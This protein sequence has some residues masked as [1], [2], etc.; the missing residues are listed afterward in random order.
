MYKDYFNSLLYLVYY[1]ESSFP[2]YPAK[3]P[4]LSSRDDTSVASDRSFTMPSPLG[5]YEDNTQQTERYTNYEELRRRNRNQWM[6]AGQRQPATGQRE[7][8][9]QIFIIILLFIRYF[10]QQI[11]GIHCRYCNKL[12]ISLFDCKLLVFIRRWC[13][14]VG[15]SL[16]RCHSGADPGENVTVFRTGCFC[17][18][19]HVFLWINETFKRAILLLLWTFLPFSRKWCKL[20]RLHPRLPLECLV[21]CMWHFASCPMIGPSILSHGTKLSVHVSNDSYKQLSWLPF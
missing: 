16:Y 15:V 9:W 8:V 5:L 7:E 6:T 11:E 12:F 14:L 21:H 3:T 18:F 2:D 10:H 17:T 13:G 19:K 1:I 20:V 4:T